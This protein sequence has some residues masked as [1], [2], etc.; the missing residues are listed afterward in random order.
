MPRIIG[1]FL[2]LS[3]FLFAPFFVANAQAATVTWD[4]GGDGSTWSDAANWDTN[5]VPGADDD[6]VISTA[7]TVNITGTTTINSLAIG[8]PGGGVASV[9]NFGY[10]A[11]TGGALVIDDGNATV[12]VGASVTHTAGTTSVIGTV[13]F[14]VQTGN[15]NVFGDI[16]ANERGYAK[17]QGPGEGEDYSAG[18]G[19]GAH[20]GDGGYGQGGIVISTGGSAYG[21]YKQP[22]SLGSGGGDY[23]GQ[24]GAGG[25]AIKLTVA[26][27]TT[28][29]G[30][31]SAN[32]QNGWHN[33][34]RVSGGGAGGSVWI[35]TGTLAGSG[36]VRANG[37]STVNSTYDGGGGGGGRVAI[38]YTTDNSDFSTLGEEHL[39]ESQEHITVEQLPN[40]AE[41]ELYI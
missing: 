15:L 40:M 41:Q 6:V 32:G 31:V 3:L 20:G 2:F 24:S 10:D 30:T 7:T 34:G 23:A 29:N 5:S 39:E 17:G 9:L 26:G 11:I 19:G 37:G 8:S 35:D 16:H 12:Y 33:S 28:V 22:T 25:G 4:G 36:H 21:N 1:L 14:D 18:A 27:T 13:F 38:Y